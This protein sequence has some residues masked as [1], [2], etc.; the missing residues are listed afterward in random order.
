MSV[1][2]GLYEFFAYA[3]P[4]VFYLLIGGFAASL[5]GLL[6]LTWQTINTLSFTSLILIAGAGFVA[7]YI[8]DFFADRFADGFR[9]KGTAKTALQQFKGFHPW[10]KVNFTADDWAY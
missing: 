5:F 6:P 2:V 9:T 10:I 4:G 7:G 8:M 1:R 3:V